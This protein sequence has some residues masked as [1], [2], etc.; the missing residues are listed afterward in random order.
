MLF[1]AALIS[2]VV[3]RE[4]FFKTIVFGD[5][6]L[7]TLNSGPV[8]GEYIFNDWHRAAYGVNNPAPFVY[9]FLYSFNQ[10]ASYVGRTEVFS[11]MM[12]LSFPLS[13]IAFYFF[14]KKFCESMW[15]RI[16][17]AAFYVINPI[18]ITYY[19]TGGFM[20][21]LVFLPLSLS[22]FI[23]LLEEKTKRNLAKAAA[24]TS[25]TIW[26][27]PY[28]SVV[29][30]FTL[31]TIA[32]G[33]LLLARSRLNFLK[34]IL[35]GLLLLSV[36][37]LVC[38]AAF[39]YAEY[40]YTQS[41]AFGYSAQSVLGDFKYTY[42]QE[43]LLNLLTFQ[44]NKA[45]PQISLGYLDSTNMWNEISIIIPIIA[46]ASVY[47][48][49]KSPQK[50]N[51]TVAMLMSVILTSLFIFI[52]RYITY[53]QFNWIIMDLSLL[54]TLRNPIKLQ[55]VLPVCMIPLFIYSI[56]KLALSSIRFFR[57][58]NPK[59]FAL[60]FTL[61][62][63]GV[64]QIYAYNSFVINGYVGIDRT[65]GTPLSYVPNPTITKIVDDSLNWY[66]EG[67]YRGIILPFDHFTELQVQFTN[68]L[69]YPSILGLGSEVT[70]EINNELEVNSNLKNFFSLLSTK[71]V[72]VNNGW[73][74]TGFRIIQP[75]NLTDITETL[76]K[77]NLTE[78]SQGQYSRFVI[79]TALPSVY[80]SSYPVFYSGV[81]TI[82]LLNDTVF[83]SEPVFLN[84]GYDGSVMNTSD[85][86]V[87]TIFSSY[88]WEMPFQGTYA[89]NAA[90]YSNNQEIPI[91]Y[92]LDGGEIEN[93]TVLM[94]GSELKYLANIELKAGSH[95]ILLATPQTDALLNLS[96]N[97][98][99][100]GS[101]NVQGNL[102]EIDNGTLSTSQ[103][104]NDFECNLKFK[105]VQFGE[106]S[107]NGP[108][109]RFAWGDSFFWRVI[110]H[111]EG[112]V[113]LAKSYAGGYQEGVTTEPENVKLGSWNL[114]QLLKIGETVSLYLNGERLL[115][116]N[117]PAL[118][119]SGRIGIGSDGSVTD[120]EDVTISKN[121]I[122]G[123]ELL[124]A[125]TPKDTPK[126]LVTLD[127]G[128]YVLQF[129]QTHNSALMLFLGE[130]Y[131][132]L[133]EATMDG[134]V[135]SSHSE[136][137]M[138][139]NSWFMNVTQG[140]HEIQIYYKPNE[141][142]RDFLYVSVVGVSILLVAAYFPIIVID[143]IRFSRWKTF[144]GKKPIDETI[145]QT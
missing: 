139:G 118:N 21:A 109:L 140:A 141:M 18:V 132:Q 63:L 55:L 83:Y 111:K 29:L 22:F 84:I 12:N 71:Y 124:P 121:I 80:L 15:S 48:I 91:Y 61:V 10:L 81:R 100:G 7:V 32:L 110:F 104:Y 27:L 97:F 122:E 73:N 99:G 143:K 66:T 112:Y 50:R 37:V 42:Q 145:K 67:T 19:N 105:L 126:T 94:T 123:L 69:L 59:F 135:L 92:S 115:T 70:T 128:K 8:I 14:S 39:L 9:L 137:N 3:A 133:W 40:T 129:N 78:D 30:F 74:D 102:L 17:G 43:T 93:K 106:E 95:R 57:K 131:D 38:N 72:Y 75:K 11:F 1:C 76:K 89:L 13:F 68:S 117:D 96:K 45:S 88:S 113:E 58:R 47:W 82:E 101:W 108:E 31:F 77:E 20:W 85:T 116:F 24:F 33:Y 46:F 35:P 98:V 127:S 28:L 87:P 49:L 52:I 41:P 54:W 107:W 4:I 136:A 34:N 16:L 56:E 6:T 53:S 130:S 65:Y 144:A 79:D 26:A 138:Y 120:F 5:Y 103:E 25:L 86:S 51:R 60:A 23:D 62:L 44:G 2:F 119:E 125:E 134:K 114:L 64:S 90:V 36:I 142:Y